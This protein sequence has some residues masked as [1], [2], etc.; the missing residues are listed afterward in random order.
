MIWYRR[1]LRIDLSHHRAQVEPIPAEL[2]S[3][4]VGGKGLATC[5]LHKELDP[6]VNPL[7]SEN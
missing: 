7:G 5:Y 6:S 3:G 1:L 4:F 2:I